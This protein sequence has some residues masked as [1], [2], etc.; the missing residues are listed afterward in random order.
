[1][2]AY[3]GTVIPNHEIGTVPNMSAGRGMGMGGST[4]VNINVNAGM[5]ADGAEVGR[6]V[7]EAI[8]KYERR[9]GPVFVSAP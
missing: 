5:G 3:S 8:R 6:Q 2:G 7:V 9:S 4:T 1:M